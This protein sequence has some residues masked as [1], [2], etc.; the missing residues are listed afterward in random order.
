MK[1]F[2]IINKSGIKINADANVYKLKS[3]TIILLFVNCRYEFKKAAKLIKTEEC[4]V[5][6]NDILQNRTITLIKKIKNCK[7]FVASSILFVSVSIILSGIM[8]YFC[9][10]WRNR[11]VLPY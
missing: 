8:I 9:L 7:S 5:E 4:D 11:G 6:V 2:V 3:V 10:K 1:K